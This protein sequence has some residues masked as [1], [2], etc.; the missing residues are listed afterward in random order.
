MTLKSFLI[1]TLLASALVGRAVAGEI[2]SSVVPA[3]LPAKKQTDTGL[4][5]TPADAHAAL[6]ADPSI[7]FLDVRDPVEVMFVGHADAADAIAPLMLVTNQF[8]TEKGAYKMMPNPGFLD[9]VAAVMA[10]EGK[11]MDDPVFVTCQSGG[12]TARAVNALAKAGYSQVYALFEGIEGDL[13]PDTGRRDLNGWKNAGL[14]WS[15]E[16]T[17]EQAWTPQG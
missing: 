1:V 4:Y 17:L 6:E 13:N 2:A 16:L 14:P 8:D 9:V 10:R 7:V 5:L 11:G 3:D 12:R 15:Y